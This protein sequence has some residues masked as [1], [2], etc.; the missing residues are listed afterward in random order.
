MCICISIDFICVVQECILNK[1]VISSS[2]IY[3]LFYIME[4]A[5]AVY[6]Q[7]RVKERYDI[8]G[9]VGPAMFYI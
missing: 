1:N 8:M 6:H 9:E 2:P 7:S 4:Q 5:Q 3:V